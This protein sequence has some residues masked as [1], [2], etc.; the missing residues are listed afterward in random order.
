[1]VTAITADIN[2]ISERVENPKVIGV[3]ADSDGGIN[4]LVDS[5]HFKAKA[6]DKI[7]GQNFSFKT[8]F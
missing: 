7:V 4:A 5:Q 3:D 2:W 1:M 6:Q 8:E